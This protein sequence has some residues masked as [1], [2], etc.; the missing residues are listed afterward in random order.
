MGYPAW[1]ERGGRRGDGDLG[2]AEENGFQCQEGQGL[3]AGGFYEHIDK[4]PIVRAGRH[5][6]QRL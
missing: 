5:M 3:K 4:M 2:A 1:S 6:R